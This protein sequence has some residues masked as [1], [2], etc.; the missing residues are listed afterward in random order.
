[1][2][3]KRSNSVNEMPKR[4]IHICRK[5]KQHEPL[6]SKA[7]CQVTVEIS[8]IFCITYKMKY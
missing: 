3:P 5:V 1:M 4:T 6:D 2:L 7:F 8:E